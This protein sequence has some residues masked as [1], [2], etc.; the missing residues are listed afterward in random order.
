M[1]DGLRATFAPA[2]LDPYVVLVVHSGFPDPGT[3]LGLDE[4]A[5]YTRAN[6]LETWTNLTI[7]AEELLAAGDSVLAAVHQ[8]GVG[9]TSDV[10]AEMRYFTL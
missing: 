1:S 8:R 6:M 4:I 9:S 3:F 10:P 7:K 5:A 2:P